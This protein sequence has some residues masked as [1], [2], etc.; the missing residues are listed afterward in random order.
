[1]HAFLDPRYFGPMSEMR[2]MRSP[3]EFRE[4][5]AECERLAEE[6]FRPSDCAAMLDAAARWRQM[7]DEEE[8]RQA[9][10]AYRMNGR[11]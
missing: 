1:M 9:F 7:A 6:A 11:S 5:A 8:A 4:R 3:S 10:A 2:P